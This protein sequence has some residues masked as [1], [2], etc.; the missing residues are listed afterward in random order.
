M[1]VINVHSTHNV[2]DFNTKEMSHY[3]PFC[4]NFNRNYDKIYKYWSSEPTGTESLLMHFYFC[5]F[6]ATKTDITFELRKVEFC[7]LYIFYLFFNKES[8]GVIHCAVE[9]N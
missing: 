2:E 1:T 6:L 4:D 3:I 5:I 9:Q 8:N 7:P